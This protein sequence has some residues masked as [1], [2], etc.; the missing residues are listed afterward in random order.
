MDERVLTCSGVL[1]LRNGSIK[2]NF[3]LVGAELELDIDRVGNC[4]DF[5][6]LVSKIR[7]IGL[8]TDHLRVRGAHWVRRRDE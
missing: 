7:S 1:G 5:G 6:L 2:C 4:F 8:R 3:R